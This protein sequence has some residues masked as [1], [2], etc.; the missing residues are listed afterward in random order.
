MNENEL[1]PPQTVKEVGIH[2]VYISREIHELK[3]TIANMPNGFATKDDH[4]KLERRVV[5]LE[6]M[7]NLKNTLLWVGLAASA[8]INIIALYNLF[9]GI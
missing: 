9:T 8:I 2:L 5:K 3:K 7:K 6:E 1:Q 4:I